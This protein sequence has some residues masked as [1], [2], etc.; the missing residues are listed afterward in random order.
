MSGAGLLGFSADLMSWRVALVSAAGGAIC[1]A[2]A[3]RLAACG[4]DLILTDLD[5]DRLSAVASDARAFG[6]QV[7]EIV[8]D[9]TDPEI[10]RMMMAEGVRELGRIDVLVNGLG[11]HLGSAAL[12]EKT[13]KDQRQSLY[14][15]NPLHVIRLRHAVVPGMTQQGW[16]RILN[17]SSVEGIRAPPLT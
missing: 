6:A 3:R 9:R 2:T 4:C 11:E 7:V 13:T 14:E 10:T 16:G 1:G 5:G 8:G 17:F 15:V 12:F